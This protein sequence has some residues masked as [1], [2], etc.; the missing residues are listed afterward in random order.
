MAGNIQEIFWMIAADS[1]KALYF[2]QAYEDIT[3][4]SCQSLMGESIV[5]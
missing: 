4:R 5:L 1:K 2:N 3:G